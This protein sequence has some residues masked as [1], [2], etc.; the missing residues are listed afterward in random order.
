MRASNGSSI[1]N[2]SKL[3]DS[4][5]KRLT[6]HIDMTVCAV[7]KK[8]MMTNLGT[9]LTVGRTGIHAKMF[10]GFYRKYKLEEVLHLADD[11]NRRAHKVAG[12]GGN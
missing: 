6:K 4:S 1:K 11:G 3:S 7:Y 8:M 5:S 10:I 9:A 2:K 12:I